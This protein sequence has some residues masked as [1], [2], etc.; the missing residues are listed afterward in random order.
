MACSAY[1]NEPREYPEYLLVVN[2]HIN[3]SVELLPLTEGPGELYIFPAGLAPGSSGTLV[4]FDTLSQARQAPNG[5]VQT[6]TRT[7]KPAT[8]K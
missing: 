3:L 6:Y 4:I 8:H 5:Q 1:P 7:L 2:G